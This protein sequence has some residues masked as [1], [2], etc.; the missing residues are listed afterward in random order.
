MLEWFW[1]LPV[2]PLILIPNDEGRGIWILPEIFYWC[3]SRFS[4]GQPSSLHLHILQNSHY[5]CQNLTMSMGICAM[6]NITPCVLMQLSSL[7]ES[8][9]LVTILSWLHSFPAVKLVSWLQD[10]QL[11]S[12]ISVWHSKI[13]GSKM[14][15][16]FKGKC[17][18]YQKG[19]GRCIPFFEHFP[20]PTKIYVNLMH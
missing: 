20:G 16:E 15:S 2:F 13:F 19:N 18:L 11:W 14:L 12:C 5:S 6:C 8:H 1:L 10:L 7:S 17:W 9:T 3:D 4:T